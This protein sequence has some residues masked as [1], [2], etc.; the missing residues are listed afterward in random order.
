[1]ETNREAIDQ[2]WDRVS[3]ARAEQREPSLA[4][5][6]EVYLAVGGTE[7]AE[8]RGTYGACARYIDTTVAQ[9]HAQAGQEHT[10]TFL[11]IRRAGKAT[12]RINYYWPAGNQGPEDSKLAPHGEEFASIETA[13][14]AIHAAV[15]NNGFWRDD[16]GNECWH[17]L[18]K[19]HPDA[20]ECG[21]FEIVQA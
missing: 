3:D 8:F 5:M 10:G 12:Y 16:D 11:R 1:M 4:Q 7:P 18:P 9:Q 20:E 21:G 14:A 17:E 13:R 15:G 6:H 19:A 2:I